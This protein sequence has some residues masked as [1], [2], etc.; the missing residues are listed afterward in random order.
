MW[1][2]NGLKIANVVKVVRL[3]SDGVGR[4]NH[5]VKSHSLRT[6]SSLSIRII[7]DKIG[8]LKITH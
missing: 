7:K 2:K 4:S 3:E 1:F 5:P 6:N 8:N